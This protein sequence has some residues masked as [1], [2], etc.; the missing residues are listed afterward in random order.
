[1]GHY[2]VETYSYVKSD[3]HSGLERVLKVALPH[4]VFPSSNK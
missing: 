2:I 4:C 1:M 3:E